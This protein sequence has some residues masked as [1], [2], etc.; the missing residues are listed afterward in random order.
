MWLEAIRKSEGDE[1]KC[2]CCSGGVQ[3]RVFGE[4]YAGS[5]VQDG[6]RVEIR[7]EP[8]ASYS[9]PIRLDPI[10]WY[11]DGGLY[12][13]WPSE[14]YPSRGGK[15][16][17]RDAW[18]AAFGDIPDGCHIHHKNG[19]VQDNRI[20]NLECVDAFKHIGDHARENPGKFSQKARDAAAAW[21]GSEAGKLW[22][23][24]HAE[25]SKSW[26]A[27]KREP[28]NCEFCGKQYDALI[29]KNG[30]TQKFCG[31]NCKAAAYRARRKSDG[32]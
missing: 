16:I 6:I 17:H 25:R 9:D 7:R 30:R 27:W 20:K 15:K 31:N 14:R 18:K 3:R 1:E 24:R 12:R 29:R 19:D 22:H 28:R 21:H 23:K 11:F 8:D 13:L 26:T 2:P 5:F 32:L 4:M 10:T